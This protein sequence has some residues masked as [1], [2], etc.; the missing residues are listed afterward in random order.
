MK[1][2]ALNEHHKLTLSTLQ[3]TKLFGMMQWNKMFGKWFPV[4]NVMTQLLKE[5]KKRMDKRLDIIGL[6]KDIKYL[7]LLTMFHL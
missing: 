7:K 3:M 1:A 6:I 2:I 4:E 5:G